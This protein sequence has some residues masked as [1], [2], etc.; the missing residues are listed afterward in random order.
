VWFH[1]I[2]VLAMPIVTTRA[3]GV[4]WEL[5]DRALLSRHVAE[6][7]AHERRI[8]AIAEEQ[9][10]RV[11][12]GSICRAG[13]AVT[14]EKA[15]SRSRSVQLLDHREMNGWKVGAAFVRVP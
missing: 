1:R 2:A 8:G 3:R 7:S 5:G 11:R 6:T 14:A 13:L 9:A 10:Q 15:G 12:S 4:L